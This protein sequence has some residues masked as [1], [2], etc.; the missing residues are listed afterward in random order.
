ML[1]QFILSS[2]EHVYCVSSV[3]SDNVRSWQGSIR[4]TR[5]F[6]SAFAS[7]QTESRPWT[8]C[9]CNSVYRSFSSVLPPLE[10]DTFFSSILGKIILLYWFLVIESYHI[11][12]NIV[13]VSCCQACFIICIVSWKHI[14]TP[15]DLKHDLHRGQSHN[16]TCCIDTS[17]TVSWRFSICLV[18]YNSKGMFS[19][20]H[21]FSL[22]CSIQTV[23]S[24][25]H[26]HDSRFGYA[27]ANGTVGVYD[28]TARYWRIKV[29]QSHHHCN[30]IVI[31]SPGLPGLMCSIYFSIILFL[32]EL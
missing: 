1:L 11:V 26:M 12:S 17:S 19:A 7:T 28:R 2:S 31:T 30:F 9:L 8:E 18:L 29:S 23:T 16:K 27:L 22:S 15:L 20:W 4:R 14:D 32:L 5:D 3:S 21:V 24:L 25:C 10:R 13:L 6:Q